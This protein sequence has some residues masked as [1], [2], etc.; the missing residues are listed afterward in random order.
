[1]SDALNTVERQLDGLGLLVLQADD[2]INVHRPPSWNV[3]S[4]KGS[5]PKHDGHG[6]KGDRVCCTDAI[7]Q[8]RHHSGQRERAC[9]SQGNSK[10]RQPHAVAN[11]KPQR[12]CPDARPAPRAIRSRVFAARWSTKAR[13]KSPL[14]KTSTGSAEAR[15][16]SLIRRRIRPRLNRI[17]L[18]HRIIRN[19]NERPRCI[20]P[21]RDRKPS[22]VCKS[23]SKIPALDVDLREDELVAICGGNLTARQA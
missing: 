3:T 8:I 4:K 10:N 2:R 1:M 16:G 21:H 19:E 23:P 14:R 22:P 7:K 5:C 13:C 17:L 18:A 6:T 20:S 11:Y 12:H 9:N 15:T